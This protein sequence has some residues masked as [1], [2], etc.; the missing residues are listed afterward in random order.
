MIITKIKL[1]NFISHNDTEIEFPYGVSIL[2]GENGSGKSSII[3]AIYY[4]ICG[5]QVRGD[6]INDLIKEGKN[7]A[8]VI[9][10]FQHGGIEYEVS[11]DRERER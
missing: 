6:T 3:D 11:R 9:L 2:M 7:S 10:N 4:S 5:E 8:R 1:K